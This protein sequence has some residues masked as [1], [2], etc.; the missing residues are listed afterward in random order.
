L[1]SGL[2]GLWEST[3]AQSYLDEG[4]LLIE[5]VI[6]ATGWTW[7]VS[8]N[9]GD[10]GRWSGIGRNGVLEEACDYWG[11]CSQDGQTFKGI[12]FHHLTLYCAPLPSVP[13]RVGVTFVA[14]T[15]L[16]QL[17]DNHCDSYSGW[18]AHNARAAYAT[19]NS[20][21]KFGMWWGT[22]AGNDMLEPNAEP[23]LSSSSID[24]RN[25]GAPVDSTWG[26]GTASQE[27]NIKASIIDNDLNDRGRGRT[28]E[29]QGGGVSVLRA[30][31]EIVDLRARRRRR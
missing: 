2:R 21:G 3:G 1:L 5:S 27:R 16:A 24:Y 30:M 19:K 25:L 4:H 17:H 15:Q 29:T 10:T 14:N 8:V 26:G 6:N 9:D 20:D 7:G 11:S 22:S 23:E 13:L 18:I 28:V 31:W 12:F